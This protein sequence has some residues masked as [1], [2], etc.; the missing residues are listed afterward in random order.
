MPAKH[1]TPRQVQDDLFGTARL[2]AGY[3]EGDSKLP[4]VLSYFSHLNLPAR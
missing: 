4:I 3:D 2:K 1:I